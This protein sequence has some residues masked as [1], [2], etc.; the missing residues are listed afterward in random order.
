MTL[1]PPA[2]PT[3]LCA[4]VSAPTVSGICVFGKLDAQGNPDT[5]GPARGN[6]ISGFRL[7][8]FSGE[9]IVLFNVA[10]TTM[11]NDVAAWNGDYGIVGFVQHGG[12]YLCSPTTAVPHPLPAGSAAEH[13]PRPA[14]LVVS[15]R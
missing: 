7:E 4:R 14:R 3:G 5:T 10:D 9:G 8:H 2:N 12:R 15:A 6:P 1:H 11:T 13:P